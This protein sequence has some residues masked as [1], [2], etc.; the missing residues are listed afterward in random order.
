MKNLKLLFTIYII[1]LFSTS[2]GFSL[3]KRTPKTNFL[4][5]PDLLYSRAIYEYKRGK[6]EKASNYFKEFRNRY[7][8]DERI[9]EV[10]LKYADSLYKDKKYI[11]A[12]E[13]Y[14]NFIRLHPKNKFVPYCYYQLGVCEYEQIST[15]DRDQSKVTSAYK[16][17]KIVV[18]Q[19]PNTQFAIIANHRILECKRKMAKYNFYVGL[20]YYRQQRFDAAI[21]RFK[22]VLKRY[23]GF[24]DDKV[25]YYL[26]KCYL[27]KN[28]IEL[29]KKIFNKLITTFP[30][31]RYR[32]YSKKYLKHLKPE[33]FTLG[34]RIK[35]YFFNYDEDIGD[36]YYIPGYKSFAYPPA[37]NVE[38]ILANVSKERRT[39]RT[40]KGSPAVKKQFIKAETESKRK[41]KVD[42]IPINIS[43]NN[44][45]YLKNGE[46]IVFEGNVV[47]TKGDFSLTSEKLIATMDKTKK[48]ILKIEASGHVTILYLTKYAT[49]KEAEY[50]VPEGKIILS[51]DPLIKDVNN[52]IK[53]EKI[54]YFIKTQQIF[55]QGS[56]KK[57]GEIEISP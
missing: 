33:K 45:K 9:I 42:N 22:K 7:P 8:L 27:D 5:D 37:I 52:I 23:P 6:Y 36:K 39:I 55:V 28:Q 48:R 12:E 15:V 56:R 50:I 34:W 17:F 4:D 31:S 26:A 30:K 35:E 2:C 46:N 54:I 11:E 20:Y 44:V 51:G 19:Y 10:E 24:I 13:A 40:F 16:Y 25:L 53:G 32:L 57:R 38:K 14:M 3:L 41:T 29:A 43:A 47:A 1:L 18:E 49:C 21:Y